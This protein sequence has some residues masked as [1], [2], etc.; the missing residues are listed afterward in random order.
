MKHLIN[1]V[2]LLVVLLF[3]CKKVDTTDPKTGN[4]AIKFDHA[5]NGQ[6]LSFE[7]TYYNNAAGNQYR[8]LML[9]YLISGV[10]LFKDGKQTYRQNTPPKIISG[11][12]EDT[13]T[14]L[15]R[16]IPVGNHDSISFSLGAVREFN[17]DNAF[18][19]GYDDLGM[20]W[21]TSMGGG[22]HF[23]RFEGHWKDGADYGGYAFHIG[24]NENLI[25]TGFPVEIVI[26]ENVSSNVGFEM[27]LNEWFENPHLYDLKIESGYTMGD[28]IKMNMLVQNGHNVFSV[29]N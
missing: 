3:A 1:T 26:E 11:K 14:M 5:V 8:V 9:K 4:L 10:T 29:K 27:N 6:T 13:Q 28:T 20:Y 7:D 15:L 22:Y 2:I 23:M 17:Y 18:E 16:N 25:T 12:Y 19:L 24:Q 21:P